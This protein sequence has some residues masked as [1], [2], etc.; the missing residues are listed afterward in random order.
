VSSRLDGAWEKL[1]E[2]CGAV[3][4]GMDW[5]LSRVGTNRLN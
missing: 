3:T 2:R 5:S 1:G 4:G